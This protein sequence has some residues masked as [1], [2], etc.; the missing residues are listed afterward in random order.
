[1]SMTIEEFYRRVAVCVING[2]ARDFI[3]GEEPSYLFDVTDEIV[4][5]IETYAGAIAP[6]DYSA[7]SLALW[8]RASLGCDVRIP[9]VN[10]ADCMEASVAQ[11]ARLFVSD[12]PAPAQ[13]GFA[14]LLDDLKLSRG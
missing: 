5:S 8:L 7:Q 4:D 10:E 6:A 1:M 9:V 14:S 13:I 2:T 12:L 3:G 11:F